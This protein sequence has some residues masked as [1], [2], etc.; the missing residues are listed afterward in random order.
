MQARRLLML[1]VVQREGGFTLPEVLVATSLL[2]ISFLGLGLAISSSS[3]ISG[4]ADF[5]TAAISR[6][7]FYSTATE[8]AQARLEEIKGATYNS[9]TDQI[10]K[11][12]LPDQAYGAIGAGYSGFRRTVTIQNGTPAAAMKTIA[13][14]VFFRPQY[15]TRIG[16]EESVQVV[17][18]IAQRP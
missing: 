17:T 13:V 6:T 11:A 12:N 18:I 1:D 16:P 15:A 2:T 10:T 7:N 5:G 9:G 4:G 14:Q 3:G 8:L